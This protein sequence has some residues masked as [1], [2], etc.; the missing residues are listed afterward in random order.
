MQPT[1]PS[2]RPSVPPTHHRSKHLSIGGVY[3]RLLLEPPP[4]SAGGAAA[5][6]ASVVERL[7]APKEFFAAA[8]HR[9]L[10]LGD[11][12]L[13]PLAAAALA[14]GV[15]SGSCGGGAGG[16]AAGGA[17]S[18]Q[19]QWDAEADRELCVRAMAAAYHVH[20]GAIGP[21]EGLPHLAALL[22]ATPSRALRQHLLLLLE[23][24]VAPSALQAPPATAAGASGADGVVAA[25]SREAAARA[26]AANGAALVEAGG[27]QLCVDVLTGGLGW[28]ASCYA[29][30]TLGN[31]P[32]S[33]MRPLSHTRA[34]PAPLPPRSPPGAA[35]HE[36]S[37]RPA[38][39]LQTGLITASSHEEEAREWWHY[40]APPPQVQAVPVPQIGTTARHLPCADACTR[41][42]R[43]DNPHHH[44]VPPLP[45][46]RRARARQ[47]RAGW[48]P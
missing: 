42:A 28:V 46:R 8:H 11:A 15:S 41:C 16:G 17:P 3:V 24:L 40:A 39:A 13:Q 47:R 29:W 20:A 10:C 7:P 27:V 36:A 19:R 44:S 38:P 35:A 6:R 14:T 37:E 22:D 1:E 25:A 31:G 21:V 32:F 33:S 34:F 23:A 2:P 9:L 30:L 26:A 12:V 4:G 18:G 48:G 43:A 5:A 45:R